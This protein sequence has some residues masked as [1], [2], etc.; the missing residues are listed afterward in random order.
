MGGFL[1][2]ELIKILSAKGH[3]I[4]NYLLFDG[5]TGTVSVEN[6]NPLVD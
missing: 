1:A 6:I 3:P 2:Q 4:T 5:K